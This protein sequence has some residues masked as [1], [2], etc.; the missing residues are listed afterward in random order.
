MIYSK[1]R[2]TL[3]M[4][5][6][7]SQIAIPVTV[8]DTAKIFYI[9][10]TDGDEAYRIP[11]GSL[12]MLTIRR[13]S[14]TYL[15]AFCPIKN[16]STIVYDF[17]QNENTAAMEGI[18]KCELTLYG[19]ETEVVATPW[20]TMVVSQRVVNGDNL[21]ITDENRTAIDAMIGAEASRQSAEQARIGAE[22]DRAAAEERRELYYEEFVE[23]VNNGGFDGNSGKFTVKTQINDSSTGEF[24]VTNSLK[25]KGAQGVGVSISDDMILLGIDE[26]TFPEGL[27]GKQ[28]PQ[29]EQGP[30]GDPYTLTEEDKAIIV[31]DV[32]AAMPVA[33]ELSV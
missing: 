20:F 31:A 15:Q 28:G 32:L 6:S 29:G 25:I 2:F 19:P 27:T 10:L 13:P 33:E 4:Q 17:L 9:S 14:G 12:A 7:H 23:R 21:N 3:D 11:G 26:T 8:G 22:L 5:V 18:H 16:N 24:I 30:Q 1:H